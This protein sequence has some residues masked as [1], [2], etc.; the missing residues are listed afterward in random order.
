M[1]LSDKFEDSGLFGRLEN[2]VF[3]C[4]EEIIGEFKNE[5]RRG[6]DWWFEKIK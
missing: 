6:E 5:D 2:R 4:E 3:S 1:A